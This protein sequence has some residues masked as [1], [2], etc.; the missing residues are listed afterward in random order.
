MLACAPAGTATS[1]T[2]YI[3]GRGAVQYGV[4]VLGA[5]GRTRVVRFDPVTR[6]WTTP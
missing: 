2:V 5:T 4:V 6:Q 3:R 1:G